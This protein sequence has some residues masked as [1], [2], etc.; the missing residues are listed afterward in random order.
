MSI[1]NIKDTILFQYSSSPI[2][3]AIIE[4]VN[5]LIKLDEDINLF[6]NEMFNILSAQGVGLDFWGVKLG[7]GR[8]IK[9]KSTTNK[10][11]YFGFN[12]SKLNAFNTFPFFSKTNTGDVVTL[13]D[14][15]YRELL[16]IK[17]AANISRTD[18]ASLE[19]L[20]ERLYSDRGNFYVLETGTMKLRYVFEF[21]LTPFEEAL[22]LRRDLPPKPAGVTYEI[23]QIKP[24]QTFGFNGS[25]MNTFNHGVFDPKGVQATYTNTNNFL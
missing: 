1:F 22:A 9:V 7:I 12:G 23:Y 14:N 8:N 6:Y 16:L 25:N 4:G 2:I 13:A 18:I 17:A 3:K 19:N 21:Y 10:Y 11:S 20:L 5:D 15:S 24:K